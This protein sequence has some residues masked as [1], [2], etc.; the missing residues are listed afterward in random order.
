V[1]RGRREAAQA[2]FTD[3]ALSGTRRAERIFKRAVATLDVA[4][5]DGE[6]LRQRY[7]P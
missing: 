6:S 4:E 7:H 5:S 3:K 1:T 2:N